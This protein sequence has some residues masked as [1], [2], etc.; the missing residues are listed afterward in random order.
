MLIFINDKLFYILACLIIQKIQ[1]VLGVKNY[2]H[3]QIKSPDSINIRPK[4]MYCHDFGE[5]TQSIEPIIIRRYVIALF[6]YA[7]C[8]HCYIIHMFLLFCQC[9]INVTN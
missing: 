7:I 3:E 2:I 9:V 5:Y 8:L 4:R 1:I 6:T